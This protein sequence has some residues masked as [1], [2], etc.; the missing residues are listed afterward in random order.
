[1]N[2]SVQ[3]VF[4]NDLVE[5]CVDDHGKVFVTNK[6]SRGSD[7]CLY[8]FPYSDGTVDIAAPHCDYHPKTQMELGVGGFRVSLKK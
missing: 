8:I 6:Q 2:Y 5:V 4:E 1:M 7:L 3:T